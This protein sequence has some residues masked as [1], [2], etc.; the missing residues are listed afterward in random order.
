[1]F[2][3]GHDLV[4]VIGPRGS[5]KSTILQAFAFEEPRVIGIDSSGGLHMARLFQPAKFHDGS[6]VADAAFRSAMEYVC[7]PGPVRMMIDASKDAKAALE[8]ASAVA[9]RAGDIE[10]IVFI[11]DELGDA[12]DGASDRPPHF[13]FA[14]RQGRHHAVRIACGFQRAAEVPRKVTANAGHWYIFPGWE[15]RDRQ[16]LDGVLAVDENP[17]DPPRY[18][19]LHLHQGRVVSIAH[20]EFGRIL[21][22][23]RRHGISEIVGT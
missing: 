3:A 2:P 5:G 21:V 13:D 11:A 15:P 6:I 17:P 16:Y 22:E 7:K 1:M 23:D 4:V 12:L 20:V 18:H 14:I 8:T 10:P 19:A 9:I